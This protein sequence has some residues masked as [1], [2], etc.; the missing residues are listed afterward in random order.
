MDLVSVLNFV[1]GGG[2]F[3]AFVTW[4]F[5]QGA[6]S[7]SIQRQ[8]QDIKDQAATVEDLDEKITGVEKELPSLVTYERHH[9]L[10]K[11]NTTE[12]CDKINGLKADFNDTMKGMEK[13]LTKRMDTMDQ[14]RTASIAQK[15]ER[16]KELNNTLGAIQQYIKDQEQ[17]NN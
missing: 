15:I 7:N 9:D 2:L 17:N 6:L 4:V 1:L 10:C 3:V 13:R 5:R 14:L 8:N 16:D 12:F 11:E